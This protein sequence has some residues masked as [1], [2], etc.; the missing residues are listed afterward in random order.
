MVDEMTSTNIAFSAFANLDDQGLNIVENDFDMDTLKSS[1]ELNQC[2][3][4]FL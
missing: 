1:M 4:F 3:L 2:K